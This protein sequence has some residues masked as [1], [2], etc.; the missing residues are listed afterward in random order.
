MR[1]SSSLVGVPIVELPESCR[2]PFFTLKEGAGAAV[3]TIEYFERDIAVGV[4]VV[5]VDVVDIDVVDVDVV[6]VGVV[7]VG[8]VGV[9]VFGA[10]TTGC[11]LVGCYS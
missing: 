6:D 8:V 3:S 1:T 2:L 5:G 9:G 4:D 11:G 10:G 7:G